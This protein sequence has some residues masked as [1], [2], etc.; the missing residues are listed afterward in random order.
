MLLLTAVLL[1]GATAGAGAADID[2]STWNSTGTYPQDVLNTKYLSAVKALMD[3]QA[4]TGDSD[5]LFHPDKAITRAEFATI[6][7]K[8]TKQKNMEENANDYFTDLDGYAWAKEYINRCYEMSWIKGVGGD[9]FAPGRE[10]T[11]AEVITV[12]IRVQR[13]Q[14]SDLIGKWPDTYINYADMY[15][16]NGNVDV[17]N[18]NTPATKG[19]VAILTN[20]II[21]PPAMVTS[22]RGGRFTG[23]TI[24]GT[25][26]T[27]ITPQTVTIEL[28]NDTFNE[29]HSQTNVTGWFPDLAANGLDAV[30][31]SYMPAG[32]SIVHIRVTGTPRYATSTTLEATIPGTF[33]KTGVMAVVEQNTVQNVPATINIQ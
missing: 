10:V 26:G 32:M 2:Y 1:A 16:L 6:V 15:N 19:D 13:G 24:S 28:Y 20:R 5:G 29:I 7:A 30:I 11:Y 23:V 9:A 18:W 12:L 3:V 17:V 21:A 27:E 33:L 25:A 14:D 8:T 31:D 22:N 4:I